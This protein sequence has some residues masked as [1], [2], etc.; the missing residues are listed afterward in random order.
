MVNQWC[1]TDE[2]S[3]AITLI[4]NN[5]DNSANDKSRILFFINFNIYIYKNCLNNFIS[6]L[7]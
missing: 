6:N 4:N 2:I 1:G 3:S 5:N 7:K